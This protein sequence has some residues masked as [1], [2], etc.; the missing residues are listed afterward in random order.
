MQAACEAHALYH[1]RHPGAWRTTVVED[2]LQP[3]IEGIVVA[4]NYNCPGAIGDFG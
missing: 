2:G 1:G 3:H 4:A